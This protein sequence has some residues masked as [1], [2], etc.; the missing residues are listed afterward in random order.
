[1][2]SAKVKIVIHRKWLIL[3][4]AILFRCFLDLSYSRLSETSPVEFPL[5]INILKMLLSYLVVAFLILI[6][7]KRDLVSSFLFRI[8]TFFTIIPLSSVYAMKDESSVFFFLT[9]ITYAAVQVLFIKNHRERKGIKTSSSSFKSVSLIRYSCLFFLLIT[10]L[11]MYLQ[12]GIP[13]LAA[14]VLENVY[15]IRQDFSVSN[16]TRYMLFVCAQVIVP[17]GIA[18]GYARKSR[19]QV[20]ICIAVQLLFYL[21]AGSKTWF[22]SIFLLLAIMLL[23]PDRKKLDLFFVG[24]TLLCALGYHISDNRIGQTVGSL[25][26]RRVLLDPAALKFSYYDYFLVKDNGRVYFASTLL[27]PVFKELSKAKSDYP[28][29]IS[30]K[31]TDKPSNAVTG[32]YG[33]DIANWGWLAFFFVPVFLYFLA[34][35][36]EKS[37]YRIGSAFTYLFLSYLFFA[38]NDHRIVSYFLDFQGAAFII[39]LYF[40]SRRPRPAKKHSEVSGQ[41]ITSGDHVKFADGV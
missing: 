23:L 34:V 15:D 9:V 40:I 37:K 1:M 28:E 21:W 25:L 7:Y 4:V 11:L 24:L 33:G 6:T 35:L 30:I 3:L 20:I 39:I 31:Y 5:R 10:V 38:F 26:N 27:G 19:I 2:R 14:L 32:I 41:M 12:L 22:F 36:A 29:D 16:Y 17:Y 8:L 18:D 13:S